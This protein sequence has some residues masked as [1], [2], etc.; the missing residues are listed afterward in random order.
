[1]KKLVILAFAL[2][3]L[4]LTACGHDHEEHDHSEHDHGD[5]GVGSFASTHQQ[6]DGGSYHV[7]ALPQSDTIVA[8]EAFDILVTIYLDDGEA[9]FPE[10]LSLEFSASAGDMLGTLA[11]IEKS[12]DNTF[13]LRDVI[14]PMA[15]MEW[16]MT[17]TL[18]NNNQ[19]E[20]VTFLATPDEA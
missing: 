19:D 17:M 10:D 8:G 5:T 14:L 20:I 13:L 2:V 4:T 11:G 15:N 1:M 6:S 16:T 7:D 18:T 9:P 12:S 3:P